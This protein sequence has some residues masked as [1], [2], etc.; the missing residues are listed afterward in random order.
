MHFRLYLSAIILLFPAL[1]VT[2][3]LWAL[4]LHDGPVMARALELESSVNARDIAPQFEPLEERFIG[5]L[6]MIGRVF[7]SVAS[8]VGPKV[9]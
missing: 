8:R 9:G 5:L 6:G 4:P 3:P 1:C 7:S 2:L